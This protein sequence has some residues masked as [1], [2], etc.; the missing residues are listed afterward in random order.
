MDARSTSTGETNCVRS[1]AWAARLRNWLPA[2]A[3]VGFH[4][5]VT[6][7]PQWGL[8]MPQKRLA[9]RPNKFLKWPMNWP[10]GHVASRAFLRLGATPTPEPLSPF[11]SPHRMALTGASGV[12]PAQALLGLHNRGVARTADASTVTQT[13]RGPCSRRE[14]RASQRH[15]TARTLRS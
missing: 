9:C 1:N 6:T 4:S 13:L 15:V 7:W 2:V 3:R 10:H 8:H 5:A 12:A 11:F 14:E